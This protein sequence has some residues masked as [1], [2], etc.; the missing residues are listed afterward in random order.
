[1][2]PEPLRLGLIGDNIHA[3]RS[4]ELHRLCGALAGRRVSYEL[5][6]PAELGLS[7]EAT[8]ARCRAD[9]LSGLNITLPYKER[10]LKLVRVADP[11]VARIGALNTVRLTQTG[12]EGFNTDHTGFIAAYRAAFGP[13]PPGVVALIGAGGVGKAIGF[14]LITLGA[15]E[16]RV[17]DTDTAKARALAL[18]LARAGGCADAC[19]TAPGALAGADGVVNATPRG[20]VGHPGSPLP[21]GALQGRRW[22]FDAVYTPVETTLKAQAEA[23]GVA[24]LSG[25]E[26]F[27][28]QGI[29]AYRLFSGRAPVALTR[30]RKMLQ[31][32]E[33]PPDG[34]D[35]HPADPPTAKTEN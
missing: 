17:V 29:Q 24:F 7:F 32:Q 2:S 31:Q 14:A 11:A 33:V 20:M 12:A 4:P 5:Y 15:S 28:Q 8:F 25:Y 9:G 16:I 18:A 27:F 6:I 3:S 10:V 19:A 13:V 35:D 26:L 22:A 34:A 23:A 1:M 30:L 21:D